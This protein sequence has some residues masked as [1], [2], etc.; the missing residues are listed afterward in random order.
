MTRGKGDFPGRQSMDDT[1][2][3]IRMDPR[4]FRV[5]SCI[6]ASP[7]V[8]ASVGSGPG[9]SHGFR[10]PAP[11]HSWLTGTVHVPSLLSYTWVKHRASVRQPVFIA[12]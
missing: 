2:S 9:W 10:S 12:K 1:Q 6:V 8:P 4:L 7:L 3:R 11:Q 5:S